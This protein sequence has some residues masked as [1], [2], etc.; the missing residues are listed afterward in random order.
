MS[1]QIC[2]KQ[3][4]RAA[5]DMTLLKLRKFSWQDHPDSI[6]TGLFAKV[7]FRV[8][9]R[10]YLMMSVLVLERSEAG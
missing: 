8:Y 6:D 9:R 1:E 10:T 2:F 4:R 7:R 3:L 5:V